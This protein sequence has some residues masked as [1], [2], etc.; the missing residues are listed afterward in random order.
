MCGIAGSINVA[1]NIDVLNY[2]KHRGPD[3]QGLI[4]KQVGDNK[5][6]LGHTRLSI[7]DLTE[8]GSQPMITDCGNY[9]IVFNGEIY[10]HLELRKKLANISFRG[11]SDTETILY[12]IREFGIKSVDDFNGIFA[13]AFLDIKNEQFYLVRDHFGVKPVYYNFNGKTMVFSSELKVLLKSGVKKE[14]DLSSLDSILTLRYNPSP[15]T[16]FKDIYKLSAASYIKYDL[17]N[18]QHK[19]ENYRNDS[20]AVNNNISL[21]EAVEEYSK[22]FENA[23]K[24][25]LLADVPVGLFLSGGLDSAFIGKVMSQNLGYPIKTFT[26]GFTGK[27]NFN[28]LE[29]A[30]TTATL[31]GS[32]HTADFLGQDQYLDYFRQS[33]YH[34]EEPIAEPTIPALYHLSK[35][36]SKSVKVV[37]SGQGADEPMAGYK[38]Y[39]GEAIMSKYAGILNLMP[40]KI[41]KQFFKANETF[42]RGV[43]SAQFKKEE[44]RFMAIY[45]LFS[46]ELK[47]K[48]YKNDLLS[49]IAIRK[50]KFFSKFY[51]EVRGKSDSLN[52]LLY[53]DTKTMLPDNLLLFNDKTTMAH[54][55]ENRVPFLDKDLVAFVETLPSE[56]KLNGKI[57]KYVERKAAENFLPSEVMNRKKRAF[58]TPVGDWFKT[59][60]YDELV[61]LVSQKSSLSDQYF[62]KDALMNM[63]NTHKQG[64]RDYRKQIYTIYSLELWYQNFYLKF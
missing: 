43:Y 54:S 9:A 56:F 64:K 48:I 1:L 25:Q 23:V 28:E 36:A 6:Y 51:E 8:A 38:R 39:Y 13:F 46:D 5:V 55:I 59:S 61:S 19:I 10:N 26:V 44:D 30:Q 2:I 15:T 16:I 47:S 32:D 7:L 22:L 57:H 34:T 60:L 12:Y 33:F 58:E 29:D 41:L 21:D 35:M 40:Y 24:R 4:E 49:T 37:L 42:Q 17:K 27:G 3:S 14:I 52:R 50:D 63:I 31:L 18:H 45:T 20:Y 53:I 11:H 62:N